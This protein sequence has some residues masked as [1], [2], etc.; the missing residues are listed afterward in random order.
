MKTKADELAKQ[1]KS[2]SPAQLTALRLLSTRPQ[3]T[4]KA[5]PLRVPISKDTTESQVAGTVA[6]A[7]SKKGLVVYFK[8]MTQVG[9]TAEGRKLAKFDLK[10]RVSEIKTRTPKVSSRPRVAPPKSRKASKPIPVA[11]AARSP[12]KAGGGAKATGNHVRVSAAAA[13]AKR[14]G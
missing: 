2:L 14:K 7:M 8:D 13:R 1:H 11:A 3:S 4:L 10:D 5:G 12:K 6:A 9:L